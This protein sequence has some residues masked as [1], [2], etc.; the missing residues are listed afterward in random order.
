MS[1]QKGGPEWLFRRIRERS[2]RGDYDFERQKSR[3]DQETVKRIVPALDP[4]K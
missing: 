2:L 3:Y 4:L 1:L